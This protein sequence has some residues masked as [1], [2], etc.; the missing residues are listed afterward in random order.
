MKFYVHNLQGGYFRNKERLRPPSDAT[1]PCVVLMNDDWDDFGIKTTFIF[2]YYASTNDVRIEEEQVKILR[3]GSALTEVPSS[4]ESLGSEYCSLGQTRK[5]YDDLLALGPDIYTQ[6]LIGINDVI[7]NRLGEEFSSEK[8]FEVSLLRF[9]EAEKL[10]R[11]ADL[12]FPWL[13][14]GQSKL[15][16]FRFTTQLTGAEAPHVVDFDFTENRTGLYRITALIG[17]N[18]TGKTQ[19]LANFA[20]AM[21]GIRKKREIGRFIPHRPSFDRVIAVSYSVFDRFVRPQEREKIFSYKYCGI[22]KGDDIL[23]QEQIR[24]K[25]EAALMEVSAAGRLETLR[26]LL[27]T[28]LS[29]E[30]RV[31]ELIAPEGK[32]HVKAFEKLSSGQ[33]IL[34]L[35]MAEIVAYITRESIILYDEPELHLHPDALAA[36]ARALHKLLDEFDSYSVIATHSPILLQETPARNVRVFRRQGNYPSV[37]RLGIESF[38]ENLTVITDEVFETTVARNNYREHL[39]KLRLD[40]GY[41]ESQIV[42]LF[43]HG[44]SFNARAF[45]SSLEPDLEHSNET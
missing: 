28:L 2:R 16:W 14:K 8:A 32:L 5:Y 20:N 15:F 17:K 12:I 45:L 30:V 4:F 18:G 13:A 43:D 27:S 23:T 40:L 29:E 26:E 22:R 9:S 3:K 7:F 31:D 24:S 6:V 42:E 25:L 19:V 36:L 38:G 11:E 10:F 34:V 44:L 41:N 35:V 21:S 39:K 33:N 1:Y 37:S